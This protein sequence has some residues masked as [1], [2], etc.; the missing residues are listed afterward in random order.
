MAIPLLVRTE[1]AHLDALVTIRRRG[2]VERAAATLD[3]PARALRADIAELE[4]S[5]GLAM[6]RRR[7][8]QDRLTAAGAEVARVAAGGLDQLER[9]LLTLQAEPPARAGSG[10]AEPG[11]RRRDGAER[12]PRGIA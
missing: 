2:S 10:S 1:L 8:G 9:L 7:R 12:P 6:L 4:R 3:R 5:F 11:A